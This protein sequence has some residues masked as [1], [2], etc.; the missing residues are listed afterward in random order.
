MPNAQRAAAGRPVRIDFDGIQ[1]RIV[2][3]P[4]LALRDYAQLHAGPPGTVFFL[5]P[6]PATGTQD[7]PGG[8]FG[9]GGNN[10]LHRYQLSTRRAVPFVAAGRRA[11]RRE[12][13]REEAALPHSGGV[14][15]RAVAVH[16]ERAVAL[17]STS[18]T[19]TSSRP[20][21]ARVG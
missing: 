19:P 4:D 12:R 8:G 20:R 2:A 10:A 18:W 1:Q 13:G 7:R 14:V 21:P 9:G 5:E 17:R 16:R 15:V 6:V 3:V 11:V